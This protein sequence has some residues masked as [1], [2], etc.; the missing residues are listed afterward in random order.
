MRRLDR[1]R[2][3]CACADS[4]ALSPCEG[5]A[6]TSESRIGKAPINLQVRKSGPRAGGGVPASSAAGLWIRAWSPRRS[7]TVVP[8]HAGVVPAPEPPAPAPS[9]G[10]R[11]RG[12]GPFAFESRF[13]P[14]RWS[15]RRAGV[16]RP[17]GPG[18]A[19][20]CWNSDE[21]LPSCQGARSGSQLEGGPDAHAAPCA[22]SRLRGARRSPGVPH[23]PRPWPHGH[24]G[25]RRV[26]RPS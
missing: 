9:R 7:R 5:E 21:R 24:H 23:P 8:V 15:P 26:V 18:G 16:F 1:L 11:A 20:G 3:A 2:G 4:S 14:E 6:C 17:R 10:P 19:P 13:F 12:G 22:P 25:N